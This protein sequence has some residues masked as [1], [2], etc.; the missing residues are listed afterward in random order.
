MWSLAF[1]EKCTLTYEAGI[2]PDWRNC[3]TILFF[4]DVRVKDNRDV[5]CANEDHRPS[6]AQ[7]GPVPGR[8]SGQ[9]QRCK[10]PLKQGALA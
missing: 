8:F 2:S 9:D 5:F 10:P 6:T 1:K 7:T 3:I 4:L